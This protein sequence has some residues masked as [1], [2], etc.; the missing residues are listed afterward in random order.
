MSFWKA[1]SVLVSDV[2]IETAQIQ[3]DQIQLGR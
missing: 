3:V 1:L 2:D